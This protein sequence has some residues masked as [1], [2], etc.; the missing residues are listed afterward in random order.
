[1]KSLCSSQHTGYGK[2]SKFP[3]P[4]ESKYNVLERRRGKK[5]KELDLI[6][7]NNKNSELV[8]G[9]KSHKKIICKEFFTP[10][11]VFFVKKVFEQRFF[12]I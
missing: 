6:S 11:Q 1:M 2:S 10:P 8:R 9:A 12:S 4:F 3:I 5:I 7:L